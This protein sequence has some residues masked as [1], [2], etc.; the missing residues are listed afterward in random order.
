MARGHLD[1]RGE[2]RFTGVIIP[3]P[4]KKINSSFI[5]EN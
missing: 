1:P 5:L 2:G 4:L 3:T